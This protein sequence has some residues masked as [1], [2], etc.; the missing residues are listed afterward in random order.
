MKKNSGTTKKRILAIV[1][2]MIMLIHTSFPVSAF[3]EDR[4]ETDAAA[5][6]SG[7]QLPEASGNTDVPAAVT[8]SGGEARKKMIYF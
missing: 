6:G 2:V 4:S 1:F 7:E 8:F 3:A 5:A